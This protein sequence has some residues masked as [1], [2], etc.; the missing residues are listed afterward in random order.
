PQ[1]QAIMDRAVRSPDTAFP[2]VALHVRVPGQ[3]TWSGAA[4]KAS[5][6]PAR[7]MRPGDR[8]RG[9]S[10]M[11]TFVAAATLQLSEEGRF[12]LDDPLPA[13][14][15]HRVIARFP[16]ADRMTVRMLL[17]HT[18]GL[19]EYSDAEYDREV[20]AHPRRRWTVGELLDRAAAM[21]PTAAPGERFGYNNTDYN[22]LG[23][24]LEEATGKPW[25]TVVRERIL[26]PLRLARTSLP[27]PGT[28]P[29]G[30][31]IARGYQ[32][33][34]GRLLDLTEIDSSMAGAAGGHALLTSTRDLARFLR[35]LLGGR[36]FQHPET[37]EA[38]RGFVPTPVENGRD[39]YG[40][41]LE[42]YVLPGGVEV[43][44]HMGTTGG[45]RAFMFHLPAQNIDLAM[46]TNSP[47]DP[48]PVLMPALKVLVAAAS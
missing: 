14:L 6:D 5:L 21:P 18:S 47:S 12:A 26:R 29:A 31:D 22:L 39:G 13:V 23:L 2:G 1:L 17:N 25:R 7:A 38:M 8:F 20:A 24:V 36:L 15:P 37:L 11:K 16:A 45:Y 48:T 10:I 34:G 33:I 19:A 43:V 35:A 42:H 3:G 46:V 32:P 40:L 41:G 27:E 28:M 9:G 44:G 30:R 4:G